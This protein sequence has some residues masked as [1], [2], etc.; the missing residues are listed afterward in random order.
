MGV[1]GTVAGR[2]ARRF[3]SKPALIAGTAV[4]AVAFGWLVVAHGHPYD[5][6]IS[7]TLLGIGIGL[8]FAALGNLIVQAVPANQTGVA[9]GMNTVMRTL[10][11]AL[12]G[13]LAATFIVDHQAH[14]LPTVTGFNEAFL[15]ATAFLVV[16]VLAGLLIPGRRESPPSRVLE[17]QL[18]PSEAQLA[19]STDAS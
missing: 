9:T 5:M 18:A 10:G 12:G 4:T 13:Q 1:L 19:A 7:A 3:G 11:G 2:L 16:C 6:L 15:T 17:P 8:A 14:G